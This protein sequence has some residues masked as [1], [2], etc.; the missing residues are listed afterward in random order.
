MLEKLAMTPDR[1]A[2]MYGRMALV[3]FRGPKTLVANWARVSAGLHAVSKLCS[4]NA[5]YGVIVRE[6][7]QTTNLTVARIVD[8]EI[9]PPIEAVSFSNH[10]F[11]LVQW[12]G[13][14]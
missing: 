4:H 12:R 11:E 13:D 7:F 6:L 9:D 1:L 10:T 3:T 5:I 14:I 8:Q 2:R